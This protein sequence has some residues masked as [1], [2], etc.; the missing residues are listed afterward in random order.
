MSKRPIGL[1][2]TDTHG[3]LPCCIEMQVIPLVT[4]IASGNNSSVFIG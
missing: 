1:C 3:P 2:I 4:K